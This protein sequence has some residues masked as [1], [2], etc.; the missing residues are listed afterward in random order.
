MAFD[1]SVY[2]TN[3]RISIAYKFRVKE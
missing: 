1:P 2:C 3:Q